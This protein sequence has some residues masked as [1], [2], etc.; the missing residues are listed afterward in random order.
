MERISALIDGE[1]D[2]RQAR[3]ELRRLGEDSEALFSWHTFHLIGDVL[4]GERFLSQDFAQRLR[5]RLASEPPPVAP[6]RLA[7]RRIVPYALSAAASLAAVALVAWMALSERALG[8]REVA[9]TPARAPASPPPLASAPS[10]GRMSE[11][12]MAHQEFSPS[13]ALQG[14][15]PYI[16]TVS[17]RQ[18]TKGH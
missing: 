7:L 3:R 1:L 10:D 9:Q 14:L 18:G 12:L 13:T 5:E 17:G 8:P 15:A 2:Q 11:Y 16:R 4:R 6:R